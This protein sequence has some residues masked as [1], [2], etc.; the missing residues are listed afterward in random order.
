MG[1]S[2]LKNRNKQC[3]LAQTLNSIFFTAAVICVDFSG[4][5]SDPP[6]HLPSLRRGGQ[7]WAAYKN[8]EEPWMASGRIKPSS[9]NNTHELSIVYAYFCLAS[10]RVSPLSD[11]LFLPKVLQLC[12]AENEAKC[13]SQS[14]NTLSF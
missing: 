11:L 9:Q 8:L 2:T 12:G 3:P 6:C 7:C 1:K 13:I 14:S 10:R 4:A 5:I